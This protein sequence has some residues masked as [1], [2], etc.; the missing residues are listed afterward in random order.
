MQ[1]SSIQYQ[2]DL[3]AW[4][5]QQQ[6]ARHNCQSTF[7]YIPDAPIWTIE[8]IVDEEFLPKEN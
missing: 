6:L 4:A 5:L 7:G 1:T 3:A 2:T 8:Q